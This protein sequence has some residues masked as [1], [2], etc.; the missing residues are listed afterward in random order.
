MSRCSATDRFAR[1][2]SHAFHTQRLA[3]QARRRLQR[4]CR[5][6][7]GSRDLVIA[8]AEGKV[9][10]IVVHVIDRALTEADAELLGRL[11][12]GLDDIDGQ[13]RKATP[14]KRYT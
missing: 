13:C 1:R 14:L 7:D 11:R 3:E 10:E 8:L 9:P 4:I 2:G 6:L 5:G 12:R